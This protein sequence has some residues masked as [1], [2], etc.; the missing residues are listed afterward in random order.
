MP[1]VGSLLGG[2]DTGGGDGGGVFPRGGAF[3]CGIDP[4]EKRS[5]TRGEDT[6]AAAAI[7]GAGAAEGCPFPGAAIFAAA[8]A[9]NAYTAEESTPP[10]AEVAVSTVTV[11]GARVADGKHAPR[12]EAAADGD[13]ADAAGVAGCDNGCG[14]STCTY[15]AR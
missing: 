3:L 6:G 15:Q 9:A 1:Q 14:E 10:R 12:E 7:T 13:A 11:A 2:V 4:D 5:P 8:V